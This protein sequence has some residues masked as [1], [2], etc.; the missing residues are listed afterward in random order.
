LRVF[1]FIAKRLQGE[2]LLE[3]FK[4]ARTGIRP[5]IKRIIEEAEDIA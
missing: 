2:E 5:A 3:E 1:I 4:K